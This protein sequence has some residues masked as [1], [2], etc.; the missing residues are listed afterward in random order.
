LTIFTVCPE[1]YALS[2]LL[3][4]FAPNGGKPQLGVIRYLLLV[5]G[6]K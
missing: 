4:Q 6:Q 2:L 1:P 3:V 5:L